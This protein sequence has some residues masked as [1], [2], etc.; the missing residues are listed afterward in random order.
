MFG[1]PSWRDVIHRGAVSATF[2]CV[3]HK[4]DRTG[5]GPSTGM[6]FWCAPLCAFCGRGFRLSWS[7]CGERCLCDP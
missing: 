6:V 5:W 7:A 1:L 4:S 2:A 3:G